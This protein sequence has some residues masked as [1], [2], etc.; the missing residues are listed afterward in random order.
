MVLLEQATWRTPCR[1]LVA[2]VAR[3]YPAE[4]LIRTS[5]AGWSKIYF[6]VRSNAQCPKTWSDLRKTPC[7]KSVL[8]KLS[9]LRAVTHKRV[10]QTSHWLSHAGMQSRVPL[11]SSLPV[12]VPLHT[13]AKSHYQIIP[14][15]ATKHKYIHVYINKGS[16]T[17]DTTLKHPLQ[18]VALYCNCRWQ[19]KD[20]FL[21]RRNLNQFSSALKLSLYLTHPPYEWSTNK[22][23][24][25]VCW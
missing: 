14:W 13:A 23:T 21:W 20:D 1:R 9:P 5:C 22:T 18:I 3:W 4:Q 12:L 11:L 25:T 10:S 16:I 8:E 7:N 15:E 24:L 17:I 2:A 6:M 19:V